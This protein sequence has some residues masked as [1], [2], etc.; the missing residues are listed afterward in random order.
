MTRF[1]LTYNYLVSGPVH[2][3]GFSSSYIWLETQKRNLYKEKTCTNCSGKRE[4]K[5]DLWRT[6]R[7]R[8][9]DMFGILLPLVVVLGPEQLNDLTG[10]LGTGVADIG[11][12]AAIGFLEKKPTHIS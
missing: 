3:M 9:G 7:Q 8:D 1:L 5:K 12:G 10:T 6:D 2:P 11:L 4:K